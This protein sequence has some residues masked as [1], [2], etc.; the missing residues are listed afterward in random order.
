MLYLFK[1]KSKHID[2][3]AEKCR[4]DKENATNV[5]GSKKQCALY[6]ASLNFYIYLLNEKMFR[7]RNNNLSNSN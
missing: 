1:D 7:Q 5:R 6:V 4:R 3:Y 2:S